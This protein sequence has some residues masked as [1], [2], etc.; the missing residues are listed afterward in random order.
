MNFKLF[1]M[2]WLLSSVSFAQVDF[3]DGSYDELELKAKKGK[4][5]Y[6]VDFYTDWC[7]YCKKMD[8]TTFQNIEIG[9]VVKKNL[10][11]YKMNAEKEGQA[12]A[13]QLKVTGFPTI[14]FFNHK[15]EVL[16]L[17]PGYKSAGQFMLL[18]DK[19]KIEV[20][21]TT[22]ISF[23]EVNRTYIDQLRIKSMNRLEPGLKSKIQAAY[24]FGSQQNKFDWEEYVLDNGLT[25]QEESYALAYFY[26]GANDWTRLEQ[27]IKVLLENDMLSHEELAYMV[28]QFVEKD[29]VKRDQL[30]W[31]NELVFQEGVKDAT[32]YKELRIVVQFAFGDVDDATEVFVS[33]KKENKKNKVKDS[34]SMEVLEELLK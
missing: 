2:L 17:H 32:F 8:A 22:L 7:G 3:F 15:G 13:H 18:L 31:A 29:K 23:F 30:K 16:G 27:Q 10:I 5:V 9:K 34:G 1:I 24:D 21:G 12:L 6:F 14:A 33:L 25:S 26:L 28:C 4:K 11:A 20:S 19:Y